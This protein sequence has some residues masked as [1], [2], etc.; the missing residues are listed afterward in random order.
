VDRNQIYEE[1]L[2]A[3]AKKITLGPSLKAIKT[4][5]L[6]TDNLLL[7]ARSLLLRDEQV[8]EGLAPLLTESAVWLMSHHLNGPAH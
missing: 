5:Q 2:G 1:S 7:Q 8:L 6:S 4:D 3:D